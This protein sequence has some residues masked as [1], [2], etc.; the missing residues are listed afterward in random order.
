MHK[1]NR[2]LFWL[3][4]I[5]FAGIGLFLTFNR[6]SRSGYFNYHSEIWADKAGYYVYLPAA[7]KFNFNPKNFP[8]SIDVKTGNG[9]RLD[10]VNNKILTKYTY[11][12][13]LLQLPF[14]LLADTFARLLNFPS[15]GFSPI[16]HWSID[17]ASVFY[18][19]LG[20]FFLGMYLKIHFDRKIIYLVLLTLFLAT[21]LYYYSI[22]ETGMSHVY[23][24]SIFCICLY[25]L[26]RTNFL[27]NQNLLI[28]GLFGIICGVIILIR[29]S[30]IIFL[31]AYFFLDIN[32]KKDVFLRLKR[33]LQIKTILPV[34]IG[35]CVIILPQLIY[36]HHTYGSLINYTYGSEG[37]TWTD[38]KLAQTWFSPNNGLFLYC[39]LYLVFIAALLCMIK[40][41]IK[42]GVFILV[43]FLTISY[44]YS[45][46]WARGFG[47]SFGARSFVEYLAVLSIP[48]AY[49]FNRVDRVRRIIFI[50]FWLLI[51]VL[52]IFNLKMTY[53]YD[54]CFYG[55]GNWDWNTYIKILESPT[56]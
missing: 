28:N 22:D 15:N 33:I 7:V 27:L 53:S 20:L 41:R 4:I 44:V 36:W 45:S 37:F 56:K 19:M 30:N 32:G 46:W 25:F 26:Q 55:S 5:S 38:P 11:G 50:G 49:I 18:L 3:A 42:N 10:H 47:C 12:V 34:L 8:D 9:F 35:F 43:L 2:V 24:F 29:P 39:P 52:L 21:N 48:L 40:A 23:S 31:S 13:A 17:V 14:F 54:G 6:H 16:Y 1:K 51:F